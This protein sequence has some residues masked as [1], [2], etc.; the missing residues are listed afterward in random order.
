MLK[1]ITLSALKKK[2]YN[3]NNSIVFNLKIPLV[4][5]HELSLYKLIPLP[6]C[7]TEDKKKC[8]YIKHKNDFSAVT[9]SKEL[10]STY[11][12][13]NP[14]ICKSVHDV[15]YAPKTFLH[16][17]S[18]RPMCE[19]L[20]MQEPQEV[21]ESCEIRHVEM[22][23]TIFHKLKHK[24]ELYVTKKDSL[25]ITCDEDKESKNHILEGSG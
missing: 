25:F 12:N 6:A 2:N 18:M 24:N 15:F 9:K 4:Y 8:M 22:A 20:L 1:G 7:V 17:R 14:T 5:Q 3:N 19:I 16:S 10:Y 13:F 21:P 23:T 11:D